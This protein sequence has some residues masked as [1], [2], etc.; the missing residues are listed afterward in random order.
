M[1]NLLIFSFFAILVVVGVTLWT[2]GMIREFEDQKTAVA[3]DH[4]KAADALRETDTLFAQRATTQLDAARFGAYLSIRT[5]LAELLRKRFAEKDKEKGF[6]PQRTR[7][8]ALA[9]LRGLLGQHKMGVSEYLA[10]R[11]RFLA[12]LAHGKPAPLFDAWRTETADPKHNPGGIPLPAPA[13][14]VTEAE[15]KL[16]HAHLDQLRGDLPAELLGP[17]LEEIVGNRR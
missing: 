15:T 16:V 5:D 4:K 2:A 17:M 13:P 11:G 3:A 6:H 14:D 9:R 8:L 1:R 12:I 10:I 7:N